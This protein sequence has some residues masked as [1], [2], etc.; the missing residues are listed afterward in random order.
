MQVRIR[1][2]ENVVVQEMERL[3]TQESLST[4][5]MM[6]IMLPKNSSNLL[7][8]EDSKKNILV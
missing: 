5:V 6:K 1:A 8:L 3:A 2:F 4:N 7:L